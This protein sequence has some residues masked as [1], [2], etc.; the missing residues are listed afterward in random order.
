MEGF[1]EEWLL[2]LTALSIVCLALVVSMVKIRRRERVVR[3]ASPG[4]GSDDKAKWMQQFLA[5]AQPCDYCGRSAMPV[6]QSAARYLCG[7]CHHEF[8]GEPHGV[9]PCPGTGVDGVR[10]VNEG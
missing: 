6:P 9:P 2:L 4:V 5:A 8:D 3:G 7:E 10:S 1:V